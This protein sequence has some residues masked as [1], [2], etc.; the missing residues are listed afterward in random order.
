MNASFDCQVKDSNNNVI[1][2]RT[3]IENY[4]LGSGLGPYLL[5]PDTVLCTGDPELCDYIPVIRRQ[6]CDCDHDG[7]NSL[8]AGCGGP[9]CRDDLIDVNPNSPEICGNQLD[10]NCNG[11]T[12]ESN[13]ECPSG[14]NNPHWECDYVNCVSAPGCG[15][16]E[17]PAGGEPVA[18]ESTCAWSCPLQCC[19]CGGSCNSPILIDVLGNGFR[20]TDF[21]RGVRFDLNPDGVKEPMAWTDAGSDDAFLVLD[22]NGNGAIDDGTELFG[23]FTPQPPSST[24]NGF[25]ALAEYDKPMSGGNSDGVID[26]QDVI[27]LSLRL[28]QDANHNAISEPGELHTLPELG[29]AAMNLQYKESRHRDRFFNEFRYRAKVLR[30]ARCAARPV[31]L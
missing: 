19:V 21:S 28:W 11:Q 30:R 13:C 9:D 1:C 6:P 3:N 4:D 31:G 7:D 16:N 27:F 8:A 5:V 23:N 18:C 17:C 20:L 25:L 10:D 26:R 2:S 14:Q 24:L 29:L 12:D 15:T 22:R